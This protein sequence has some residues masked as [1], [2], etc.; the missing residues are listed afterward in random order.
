MRIRKNAKLSPLLFSSHASAPEVLQTHV[1]QLNQSPW[2]VIPFS[3]DSNQTEGEDSFTGNGSLGDSIGA[4][5]SSVASMM[6]ISNEKASVLTVKAENMAIIDDNGGCG[7]DDDE[8]DEIIKGSDDSKYR[9]RRIESSENNNNNSNSKR[10]SSSGGG[11]AAMSKIII[12]CQKNDGKG[13]Q[14]KKE[15]KEGHNFCEHHLS[16]LRSYSSSNNNNNAAGASAINL[17][18]HSI[19]SK[20]AQTSLSRRTRGSSG[21]RSAKKSGS[22]SNNNPYEFYYYSGF[23]PLWGRKRGD[24]GGGAVDHNKNENVENN[25]VVDDDD[26]DDD[27]DDVDNDNDGKNAQTTTRSSS[28]RMDNEGFDYVDEDDDDDDDGD[29]DEDDDD[30]SGGDSGKKRMRKPVKARSL[31]SLM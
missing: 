29:D 23:G 2:D 9:Q 28:S 16:L 14:C 4:V 21:T 17:P 8:E 18:S 13:W 3:Q 31:K 10:S 15:A 12:H 11:A 26:D 1:C 25:V 6:D 22:I 30:G 20:K 24:R 7:G 19:S 27:D 5:E